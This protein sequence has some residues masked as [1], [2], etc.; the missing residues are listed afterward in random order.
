T[1]AI[2][3]GQTMLLLWGFRLERTG[4]RIT[5]RHGLFTRQTIEIEASR[6]QALRLQQSVLQQLLGRG[7]GFGE[8]VG[9]SDAKG[10]SSEMFPWVRRDE[11]DGFVARFVP[12]LAETVRVERPPTR[13]LPRFVVWPTLSAFVVGALV[14][15][16]VWIRKESW[17][18]ALAWIAV[19]LALVHGVIAHRQ[20]GAGAEG[21]T[22]RIENRTLVS[23]NIVL[24]PRRAVRASSSVMNPLQRWR[25]LADLQI[26]VAA[27][28]RGRSF[29]AANLDAPWASVLIAWA[30][31]SSANVGR[32]QS[33]HS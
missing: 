1:S 19:P 15:G 3:V 6:V 5:I 10:R 4:A 26:L 9:H 21:R 32:M 12:E 24:L 11:F 29:R 27:G 31:P 25:R 18:G 17:L 7:S 16:F 33:A 2:G 28:A 13:A 22:L 8:V 20:T 30:T 23:R 14:C